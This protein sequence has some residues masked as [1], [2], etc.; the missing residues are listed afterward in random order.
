MSSVR[1][2][3]ILVVDDT[4][5][6]VS[7]LL[8]V[9][10]RA[11]HKVL[12]ARD[13]ES[14]LEQAGYAHPELILLD[15]MM[16]GLDGFETCKRLKRE[17]MTAQIPVIFMTALSELHDKVRAFEA[18]AADYVS[19]P[20]Q[21]EEVLA[22]VN[23]HLTLARLTRELAEANSN[24]EL[25]VAART[26]ELKA[27]L[28][29]VQRLQQRLQA[30]N[31]YLQDEISEAAN[32]REI[33]GESK[34]LAAV[35]RKID[36]VARGDTTVLIEGETGTGKELIARAIHER[37]PRRER[38]LVKLNCSAISAGLVESE[39]FGHT[40]GAFTGATE[41]RIGRFELADGGTLFLDEVSE[42]PLETQTKLL[43]VLQEQEFEPVGSSKPVRV[44]VRVI[45]ATNRDLRRDVASGRFRA[46]LYY[47]LNVFPIEVPPLRARREDIPELAMH[48]LARSARKLGKDVTGIQ[49]ESLELLVEHSWPGNVRDLQN[50]IERATVLAT[51]S[52]LVIDWELG[53]ELE[54]APTVTG[55][56]RQGSE[57]PSSE[58]STPAPTATSL[59]EIER[60]HIIT[61]LRQTRGV[62]E[63]PHGAARLLDLKPSTARFRIKKLGI[64]R[65]EYEGE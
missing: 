24:L 13:G 53:P 28:E 21:H 5:T 18:G 38:P 11:G 4:P 3:S 51:G 26:T 48:F 56:E 42:L 45:A 7:V 19:K 47:R 41:R 39:L 37:S 65:G 14:A 40:K 2:A 59:E 27:A 54:A 49:P 35:M 20:F 64:S 46:D 50:A 15:V 8:E 31:R 52:E 23:V 25:K 12:V 6:N 10:G 34:A 17:P 33:I 60:Q 43:R 57:L 30:E 9:L 58:L 32:H 44:D 55:A 22:R 63:G 36:Q 29:Q 62:I 16:P 1:G 61:V